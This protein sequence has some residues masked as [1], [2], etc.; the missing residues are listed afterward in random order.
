[1]R[2]K[3]TLVIPDGRV[4]RLVE[5]DYERGCSCDQCA[6]FDLGICCAVQC[7]QFDSY[8]KAY[9][10]EELRPAQSLNPLNHPDASR[11]IKPYPTGEE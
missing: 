2:N 8:Y 7:M 6:L 10:F 5:T 1:M 11:N 3:I 4:F 9:H